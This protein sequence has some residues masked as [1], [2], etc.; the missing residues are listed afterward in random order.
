M[1]IFFQKRSIFY[2]SAVLGIVGFSG[3]A[4]AGIYSGPTDTAHPVDP[5]IAAGDGRFVEW[6]DAIDASRTAFAPRGSTSISTTGFNSLGDLDATE[7]ANGDA[8]GFLTVT[9]PTGIRDGAGADFAVFENGFTFGTNTDG[10][11]GLFAE[12]AFVEVSSNGSDFARFDAISLNT[13]ALPGGFGSAFSGFD[14]TN[15]YNLA[16]K[17]AGGFGTPFDLAELSGDPLVVGGQL[18]LDDIQYVRLVDIP[19]NGSFLDSQ[20]NPILDNWLTTGTGGFDFRL[21]VGQGVGVINTV[22]E[23]SLAL[24]P[25][26]A[27][28]AVSR[29]RA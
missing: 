3:H 12:F 8:P 6:A 2:C 23:P 28:W 11:D 7:I 4:T 16:G 14:V 15:V 1:S 5:A 22:P 29:R 18:D 26:L 21:P 9:F 20:G 19:G 13:E 24:L 25:A 10:T 27:V 17:H